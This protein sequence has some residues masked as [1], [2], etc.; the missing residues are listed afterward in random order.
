MVVASKVSERDR[1]FDRLRGNT[2][3]W[4][5]TKRIGK[6]GR[7]LNNA[8]DQPRVRQALFY[9]AAQQDVVVHLW[10]IVGESLPGDREYL[11]AC[12]RVERRRG[13]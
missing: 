3:R 2:P 10:C 11:A 4:Y 12:L 1:F 8:V 13:L 6:T 5:L 7:S 9:A